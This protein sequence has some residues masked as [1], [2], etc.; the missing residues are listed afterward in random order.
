MVAAGEIQR[1]TT[2]DDVDWI[3]RVILSAPV[4]PE[5]PRPKPR[6]YRPMLTAM[7]IPHKPDPTEPRR[8]PRF[9]KPTPIGYPDGFGYDDSKI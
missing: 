3:V 1:G 5:N 9:E 6:D 8:D 4:Y 7:D 2:I